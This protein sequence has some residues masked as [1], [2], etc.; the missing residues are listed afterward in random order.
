MILIQ[1]GEVEIFNQD[2]YLDCLISQNYL[3]GHAVR[4]A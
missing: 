1:S 2:D 4:N 3:S